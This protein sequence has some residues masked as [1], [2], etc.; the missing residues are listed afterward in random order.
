M[1]LPSAITYLYFL[2]R[3]EPGRPIQPGRSNY[4]PARIRVSMTL[5]VVLEG[6]QNSVGETRKGL[7][8]NKSCFCLTYAQSLT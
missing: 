1:G 5:E 8:T 7:R 6:A 4:G 3:R 2:L